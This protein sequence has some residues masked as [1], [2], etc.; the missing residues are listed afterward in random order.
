MQLCSSSGVSRSVVNSSIIPVCSLLKPSLFI[1]QGVV[2]FHIRFNAFL[3]SF[4]HR[5][6]SQTI[7]WMI[8]IEAMWMI[9]P[10]LNFMWTTLVWKCLSNS[11]YFDDDGKINY[12]SYFQ[13]WNFKLRFSFPAEGIKSGLHIFQRLKWRRKKN[14]NDGD[15]LIRLDYTSSSL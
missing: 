3:I 7:T 11:K 13:T 10:S 15:E 6:Q 14:K 2:S 5:S 12:V 1:S 8:E 4:T 9:T